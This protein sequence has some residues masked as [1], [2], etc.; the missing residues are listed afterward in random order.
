MNFKKDIKMII[1]WIC[2]F[3]F[4]GLTVMVFTGIMHSVDDGVQAFILH[5]RNSKLTNV[6]TVITNIGGAYALLSISVLLL[7]IKRDKKISLM[8]AINLAMVFITSQIF[9]FIFRR[10]RPAEIFLVNATGYSYPSGHMMVSSAFYFYILYLINKKVKNKIIKVIIFIF[11]VLLVFLIGF[12]RIYLGVH[13]TTD[14]IGG[15]I[16]AILYLMIYI[17]STEKFFGDNK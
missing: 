16:L 14:I 13:Y 5:I 9:K 15:L 1:I 17:K 7:L 3:L 2:A 4:I 10:S 6:F 12:S 11:T 8:I